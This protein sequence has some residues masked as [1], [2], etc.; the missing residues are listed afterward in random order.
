MNYSVFVSPLF[1]DLQ[2]YQEAIRIAV[3]ETGMTNLEVTPTGSSPTGILE[4]SRLALHKADIFLG[5]YASSYG[6]I[7]E[8]QELSLTEY[9]YAEARLLGIPCLIYL[10]SPDQRWADEYLK[11]GYEGSQMRLFLDRLQ[12]ENPQIRSFTTPTDLTEKVRLD[13]MRHRQQAHTLR[14][15]V[16]RHFLMGMLMIYAVILGVVWR[17]A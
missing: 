16:R 3:Y 6:T 2:A 17:F 11:L 8:D 9:L 4:T 13:L 14:P 7:M 15:F 5:V 12:Q 1:E 10:V